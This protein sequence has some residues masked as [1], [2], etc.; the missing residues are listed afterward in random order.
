[1]VYDLFVD[2]VYAYIGILDKVANLR[3]GFPSEEMG[4]FTWDDP[5]TL[6]GV[7]ILSYNVSITF[8]SLKNNNTILTNA[9]VMVKKEFVVTDPFKN[10]F[11]VLM[12]F[13]TSAI[14]IAG[15]GKPNSISTNFV[16]SKG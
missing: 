9:Q 11:C 4:T 5:F 15:E 2:H 7:P 14:N 12:N 8:T 1:M 3:V 16:E 6:M 13:T 10:G